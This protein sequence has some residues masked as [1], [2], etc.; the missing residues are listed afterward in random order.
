MLGLAVAGGSWVVVVSTYNLTIQT[1]SPA[2]V[3]GRSLSLFHSFIVGGLSIGSY[4]WGVAAQ[5][6]SINSAFA[7]SALMMAASA[8]LAAWLP[9]PTHEA[10]GERTHGEPRRT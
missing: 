1:A 9:L 7:V 2:W 3:A 8:C 10:L 5:G 6:S 4:L